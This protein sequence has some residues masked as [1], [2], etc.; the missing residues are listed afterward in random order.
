MHS[1]K[2]GRMYSSSNVVIQRLP[3]FAAHRVLGKMFAITTGPVSSC[4]SVQPPPQLGGPVDIA[5]C[6]GPEVRRDAPQ[7]VTHHATMPN[8]HCGMGPTIVW[9]WHCVLHKVLPQ[10]FAQRIHIVL[11]TNERLCHATVSGSKVLAN[12]PTCSLL[13]LSAMHQTLWIRS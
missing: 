4:C 7:L 11:N 12:E 5:G 13:I 1:I 8:R 2:Q 10:Y 3:T 9:Y 6:I